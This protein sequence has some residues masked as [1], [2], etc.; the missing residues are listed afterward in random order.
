MINVNT[1]SLFEFETTRLKLSPLVESD[2]KGIFEL[3]SEKS[4]VEYNELLVFKDIAEAEDI[5]ELFQKRLKEGV[6]IRWG[7]HLKE[8]HQESECL[9]GTCGFNS[10]NIKMKNGVV[11]YDLLPRHWGQGIATEAMHCI[12]SAA[13]LGKLSCGKLNR[14][15]ADTIVTNHRS[16]KLL[17]KLGFRDEGIR[18]QSGYWKGKFHDLKCFGLIADEFKG[19]NS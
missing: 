15:Q 5:I 13:F 16:E 1:Q 12:I 17:L 14:I 6:G 7:I 3:F 8:S 10:W 19:P 2:A 18:R 4:V 9:I 11:G